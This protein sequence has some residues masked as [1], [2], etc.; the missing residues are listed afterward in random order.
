LTP[1]GASQLRI[2]LLGPPA[3]GKGTQGRR[4]A[5]VLQL[6]YLSTGALLREQVENQTDLGRL[7]EPILERGEYLPDELMCRII[8]EWLVGQQTGWVLDGFPRSLPQAEFLDDWLGARRMRVDRAI[9]LEVPFDELISRIQSRVECPQCRWSGQ[10]SQALPQQ[11][12]P[13]C[14]T[15]LVSRPDDNE[16]NFTNRYQEFVR[17][18]HPLVGYYGQT[19]RLLAVDATGPQDDVAVNLLHLLPPHVPCS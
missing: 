19:G 3:S 1:S 18:T 17:L 6:G 13:S 5:E 16:V 12:C 2:V 10:K 4:L 15:L 8:A 9:S 14:K 11:R 7:A